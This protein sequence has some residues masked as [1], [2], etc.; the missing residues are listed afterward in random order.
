MTQSLLRG[1]L[2]ALVATFVGQTARAEGDAPA[3]LDK[4]IKAL[5]GEE[6]LGKIKAFSLKGKGTINI[7]GN[8]S[9][10]SVEVVVQGL[11]HTRQ[12]FEG[13]FGGNKI[14]GFSIL[15]GDK[16]W[17]SFAGMTMDLDAD[18]LRE[19]KRALYLQV[20][21]AFL[22]PLK[23]KGFKVESAP[24]EQIDGKN[25]I[26]LKITCPDDKTFT[27]YIDEA[28]SLP[29]KMAAKVKDFQGDEFT[30]TTTYAD[31]KDFDGI[32]KA[33]KVESKRDGEKFQNQEVTE[34]KILDSVDPKTFAEPKE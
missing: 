17:R 11:D 18:A 15:A 31:Y 1:L 24:N 21:P 6:K 22:V 20:G 2:V 12:D 30:Q 25:A 34:F 14:K 13:E 23:G 4:A 3:I 33:T 32:K 27:L 5:G 26:G 10:F 19:A 9:P 16:G 28:T 8:D 29:V 7:M